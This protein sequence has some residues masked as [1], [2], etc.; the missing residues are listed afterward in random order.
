MTYS[1]IDDACA[2]Q[3]AFEHE[4][5]LVVPPLSGYALPVNG[6][7]SRSLPYTTL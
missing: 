3:K 1:V 2:H 5:A 4:D 7:W 6:L